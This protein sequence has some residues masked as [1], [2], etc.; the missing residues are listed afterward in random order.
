MGLSNL[1]SRG[2]RPH[3]VDHLVADSKETRIA[4]AVDHPDVLVRGHVF[5]D[6]WAAI[7]PKLV[8]LDAWPEVPRDQ[9]WKDG[10]CA[11][12]GVD[13]PRLFWKQLLAKVSSYR[14]LDPSLVGAVEELIDFVTEPS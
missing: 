14:D 2:R 7:D 6:V 5:V 3:A 8:G 13:D 10:I 1:S 12:A 4:S 9:V 11:A